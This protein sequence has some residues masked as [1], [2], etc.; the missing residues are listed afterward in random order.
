MWDSLQ[1]STIITKNLSFLCFWNPSC[2]RKSML[3][4]AC[5]GSRTQASTHVHGPRATLVFYFRKYIFAYL[6]CYI[7]HFNTPQVNLISDQALNWPW[8][9]EFGHHWVMGPQVVRGTKCGVC[10]S[11]ITS[12]QKENGP[13]VN[14][15]NLQR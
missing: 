2:L 7:F 10:R 8:A 14:M 5:F 1:T 12:T 9:L 11:I 4:Y 15:T 3:A 13:T 6:K